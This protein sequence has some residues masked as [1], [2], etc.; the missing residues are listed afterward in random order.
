MTSSIDVPLLD[1]SYSEH[2]SMISDVSSVYYEAQSTTSGLRDDQAAPALPMHPMAGM[3]RIGQVTVNLMC[4]IPTTTSSFFSDNHSHLNKKSRRSK[5]NS[6]DEEDDDDS[7]RIGSS[8]SSVP[9]HQSTEAIGYRIQI[10]QLDLFTLKQTSN[11]NMAFLNG[12][13]FFIAHELSDG[14]QT[15]FLF[16]DRSVTPLSSKPA[17]SLSIQTTTIP[18]TSQIQNMIVNLTTN[19]VVLRVSPDMQHL[20]LLL[21]GHQ[22]LKIYHKLI[23]LDGI[24]KLWFHLTIYVLIISRLPVHLERHFFYNRL[25]YQRI[26]NQICT[27]WK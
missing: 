10:V 22:V 18:D 16:R 11:K 12:E 14:A 1:S 21:N 8:T 25:R 20:A 17:F 3:L 7:S 6:D 27:H 19:D 23:M 13:A 24:F 5:A 15:T 4:D 2:A 9:R 26:C